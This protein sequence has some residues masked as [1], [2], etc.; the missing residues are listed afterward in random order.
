[1]FVREGGIVGLSI[2]KKTRLPKW[3]VEA[4]PNGAISCD[5]I[6]QNVGVQ[7]GV[8]SQ[9]QYANL[10][11]SIHM[12]AWGQPIRTSPIFLDPF[13]ESLTTTKNSCLALTTSEG[14]R[15]EGSSALELEADKEI[16]VAM[17]ASEEGVGEP[18]ESL[19]KCVG[20]VNGGQRNRRSKIFRKIQRWVWRIAVVRFRRIGLLRPYRDR[21][22][23]V[24]T[25]NFFV[26][27]SYPPVSR[28]EMQCR[29]CCSRA[30][31][32]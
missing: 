19:L 5:L 3:Q 23:V 16:E 25:R 20:L 7:I 15:A 29:Q 13:L 24:R 32:M 6:H 11:N 14:V 2:V 30:L 8:S 10:L 26:G 9:R 17:A 1:V 27:V 22:L 12:A 31:P 21:L 4:V 28:G 18:L